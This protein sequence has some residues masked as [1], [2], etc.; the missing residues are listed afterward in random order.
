MMY[1]ARCWP[2]FISSGSRS[3]CSNSVHSAKAKRVPG[4]SVT[5]PR[6]AFAVVVAMALTGSQVGAARATTLEEAVSIAISTHPTVKKAQAGKRAADEE[7][8]EARAD[9][10]PTLDVVGEV[11]YEYTDNFFTRSQTENGSGTEEL[12]RKLVVGEAR[13]N[14]FQGF[15]RFNR[16]AAAKERVKLA[17]HNLM[18]STEAIGLRATTAY[19][20]VLRARHVAMLAEE[21][22]SVHLDVRNNIQYKAEKGR[23]DAGD[24]NQAESR[25]S[26]ARKR[27]NEAR[28]QL[29]D[30]EAGYLE[31]VG[32]N[33]GTLE[34]PRPP[35]QTV[36]QT[37]DLAVA[38]A[39]E[40]NPAVLAASDAVRASGFDSKALQSPYYPK[41]DIKLLGQGGN[42]VDGVEGA[43]NRF[44]ALVVMDYNLYR[45]GGDLARHRRAVE[46]ASE[47]RQRE[48]EIRR[49][50]AEQMRVEYTALLTARENLPLAETRAQAAARVVSAYRQQFE[51]GRRS[52]LDVLDVVHE[53][54]EANV[55]VVNTDAEMMRAY[56][57]VL[58]T[59]GSLLPVLNVAV[60]AAT[61]AGT[62]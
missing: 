27:L 17:N 29:R 28:G 56:Y 30:A 19:I 47:A 14:L 53:L 54:F 16:T 38:S 31:A 34:M 62:S 48:A 35:H 5:I 13:Q 57:R 60:P 40:N 51:L 50:V 45:G 24:F 12:A 20:E 7:V 2:D 49:L 52:L 10:F 33:P 1:S 36:P 22:V 25:L 39:E 8:D 59:G 44:Q 6:L 32:Q 41:F 58:A 4:G 9:F 42:D 43:D 61:A 46:K 55:G 3:D 15:G 37:I 11:G 23:S 21:N 26:L 18:D